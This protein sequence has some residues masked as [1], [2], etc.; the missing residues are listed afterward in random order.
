VAL[1]RDDPRD[2]TGRAFGAEVARDD[3]AL[4]EAHLT[5][6]ASMRDEISF[7]SLG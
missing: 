6:S 7:S 1:I 2:V 3:P 4:V 5:A